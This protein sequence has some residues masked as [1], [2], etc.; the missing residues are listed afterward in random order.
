MGKTADSMLG[1]FV[2]GTQMNLWASELQADD[3]V[4][5]QS[6]AH[7]GVVAGQIDP[8][9]PNKL[10]FTDAFGNGIDLELEAKPGGFHQNVIFR[11][12][13]V[14][15]AGFSVQNTEYKLFT[16]LGLNTLKSTLGADR[17]FVKYKNQQEETVKTKIENID[18]TGRVKRDISFVQTD[19]NGKSKTLH[20]F[21]ESDILETNKSEGKLKYKKK[22]VAEKEIV[23]D[24]EMGKTY[25]VE[26]LNADILENCSYPV[27]W[28]Y[29]SISG[30]LT[31]DE[32]WYADKTYYIS[33]NLYVGDFQTWTQDD[34]VMLI[35][36]PGTIVKLNDDVEVDAYWGGIIA[37]GKPFEYIIFTS[38]HDDSIGDVITGSDGDPNYLDW[39]EITAYDNSSFT[40]CKID[41]N[42]HLAFK[43]YYTNFPAP[44][45]NNIF[46]RTNGL[47]VGWECDS[48]IK[49]FNNLFYDCRYAITYIPYSSYQQG[50]SIFN[51]TFENISEKAI[52]NY[53]TSNSDYKIKNNLYSNCNF[54]IWAYSGSTPD[55]SNNA[56]YNCNYRTTGFTQHVTDV[57]VPASPYDF[58]FTNLGE[59]YLNT[60][61]N[62]GDLLKNAGSCNV[63]DPNLYGSNWQDWSIYPVSDASHLFTSN[64]TIDQDTTW[65]PNYNT[66]DVNEVAI[67]YHHPRVDY[68]IDGGN[69]TVFNMEPVA[70]SVKPGTVISLKNNAAH[71]ISMEAQYFKSIGD[72]LNGYIKWVNLDMSG[73]M[74]QGI[75]SSTG[76]VISCEDPYSVDVRYNKFSGLNTC[77]YIEGS[78]MIKLHDNIFNL[79]DVGFHAD[80]GI[81]ELNNCLFYNN[82][83]GI[84]RQSAMF[85]FGLVSAVNCTFD[86]NIDAILTY[87]ASTL[88]IVNSLFTHNTKALS[89]SLSSPTIYEN[90]NAFYNNTTNIY[91]TTLDSSDWA[92]P[93]ESPAGLLNGNPF[94]PNWTDFDDR[95]HLDPNSYAIGNGYDPCSIGMPGYTSQL[96]GTID[97][98]PIDIGYHYP[99]T[100][101]SDSDGLYDYT[102][103][104]MATDHFNI[105]TDG[106]GLV[107]GYDDIVE[108]SYYPTGV[109][110]DNDGYVDGELTFGTD[111]LD[112]DSDNDT[113]SDGV[114]I[115]TYNTDPLDSDTDNDNLNDGAEVY[116]YN[117]DPLDS[118][119]D[120]DGIP[121]GWEVAYGLDPTDYL[122][123]NLDSDYDG[124]MN[125]EEY[126]NST[127]PT[128]SDSDD[129]FMM[130]GWEVN[131]DF[132]P[133]NP[134]DAE[135]D[136]DNDSYSNLVEFL[137]HSSPTKDNSIP[138]PDTIEV[139]QKI[140][141]IQTAIDLSIYGDTI[142]VSQ[143]IYYETIEFK[144]KSIQIKGTDPN[145]WD[146]VEATIID[147]NNL[148]SVISF[149]AGSDANSLISG[150]TITGGYSDQGAGIICNQSSPTITKCKIANNLAYNDGGGLYAVNSTPL[151][152]DCNFISN[153]AEN[154][155][156]AIY[157]DSSSYSI[158]NCAF[159]DNDANSFDGGGIFNDYSAANIQNCLFKNNTADYGGAICNY[160]SDSYIKA[161]IFESNN[162]SISGGG[163]Y[164]QNCSVEYG[165]CS[166][167]DN[168]AVAGGGAIYNDT[169]SSS[170]M[171]K[172]SVF[173][174]N[175]A[176]IGGA[177]C[178][179]NSSSK[180]IN[181]TIT[182]NEA[183]YGGGIYNITNSSPVIKNCIV[184]DNSAISDGNEVYNNTAC[185]PGVS[186]S[187]IYG[188]WIDPNAWNSDIG[189]NLGGNMDA[190]PM[191]I[192]NNNKDFR[193]KIESPCLNTGDPNYNYSNWLDFDGEERVRGAN[194]DIG[195]DESPVIWYIDDDANGLDT[196]YSLL[197]AFETVSEGVSASDSGDIILLSEGFYSES[198][199]LDFK[200]LTITG[201]DPN[202]K[203]V[204]ASTVI[205]PNESE[206]GIILDNTANC[207]VYGLTLSGGD[208]GIMCKNG[209]SL[210]IGKCLIKD[211]I[212]DGILFY[213][214]KMSIQ[215][216]EILNNSGS[217]I[218]LYDPNAVIS[219]SVIAKNSFSGVRGSSSQIYNCTIT[220]NGSY[221]VYSCQ[222]AG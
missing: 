183:N 2:D 211:N 70:L 76:R 125:V 96:T 185:S 7:V 83:T 175:V 136:Q 33:A 153:Y 31:E 165:G 144:G 91:G 86:R 101:Q 108:T 36:E 53:G 186:Y 143:G 13:P 41:Y 75:S 184:W 160:Y 57:N 21:G 157:N 54:G 198:V 55:E 39:D 56:F 48:N 3:G 116:I 5:T 134:S 140:D 190:N 106:D 164:D 155:G 59:Y 214:G 222:F 12:K 118:D 1:Y 95:F 73:Q 114:E 67:G 40:F 111:P 127:D 23:C 112:T 176:D 122:D 32:I 168:S 27:I 171:I 80:S 220:D 46:H 179:S 207:K 16:E 196:G 113:I 187:D 120:D 142:I 121:D 61:P 182:S 110:S 82:T 148:N 24:S 173:Y 102:E 180:L 126:E 219:N 107:D 63:N 163:N 154:N 217:G 30:T 133:N 159:C 147:A 37:E 205:E 150:I 129:D 151:I 208:V 29:Q 8:N 178:N 92:Y 44:L 18:W 146:V 72:Q 162:A 210:S 221:G 9:N 137:H 193:I 195:F 65:Q 81:Y 199:L 169:I 64:T 51:N 34:Q 42:D 138:S 4:N 68:V 87:P 119:T 115:G 74:L 45:K 124:L 218:V 89:Y 188:C 77:L 117:T 174:D 104:W 209:S 167:S 85:G 100:A 130:D 213:S 66:C 123:G 206:V 132:N 84:K 90:N 191:F 97:T 20:R 166:F 71:A 131:Y 60:D 149:I 88:D 47:I 161:S 189:S 10:V 6:I 145:D 38:K 181:C 14:L 94:D 78:N 128:D 141:S 192:S 79:S 170:A 135:N 28:D 152:S 197:D 35:I 49:V 43:T 216:C 204:I 98:S 139:P 158:L 103:F 19:E 200:N 17:G 50:L 62:G 177:I 194:V 58:T 26:S 105:D 172:N 203:A 109:D 99:T 25:L 15:P 201:Y 202:N 11:N 215:N 52:W 212:N 69:I 22:A 156:G 93:Q